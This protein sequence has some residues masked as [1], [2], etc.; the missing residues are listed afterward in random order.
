MDLPDRFAAAGLQDCG[1]YLMAGPDSGHWQSRYRCEE[2]LEVP[3]PRCGAWPHAWCDRTGD[4]L[5]KRGQALARAGTPPS[6]QERMWLRQGH[7]ESEFPALLARQR[8]GEWEDDRMPQ[9]PP[10]AG[11]PGSCT[12][13]KTE[14]KT[15]AALNSPAFPVDF[16]CRHPQPETWPVPSY[17][18]RYTAGRPCPGCGRLHAAEVVV[19]DP[20]TIGCRCGQCG[21]RWLVTLPRAA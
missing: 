21:H 1:G 4:R 15:R 2:I 13:C 9:Q 6:H 5:S 3:C 19:Q 17:P 20:A 7:D 16:P 8:P 11:S 10:L 12:P 14:R 18:V